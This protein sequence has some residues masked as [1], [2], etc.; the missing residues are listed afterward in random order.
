MFDQVQTSLPILGHRYRCHEELGSG[1]MGIVSRAYDRLTGQMVAVKLINVPPEYFEF[2][3]RATTSNL[4]V[5]LAREFQTLASLR[6]PNIISVLDYGFAGADQPF[7]VMELLENARELSAAGGDQSLEMQMRLIEQVL[8]ALKYLHRHRI[9]HCDLKPS[10]VLVSGQGVA[11]VLDFG[12]AL[13]Q[14]QE[15]ESGGTLSYMSPEVMAGG[16][17]TPLSDLYA[18]GVMAYELLVGRLPHYH[19]SL[20]KMAKAILETPTDLDPLPAEWREFVGRLLEKQPTARYA[21]A[22]EA[23]AALQRTMGQPETESISIRESYLQGAPFIGRETERETLTAALNRAKEGHGS[24]WLVSGES[25]VGKSRLL[26]ELRTQAQV[27]GFLVLRGQAVE[28]AGL[29]YQLWR[30]PL[31]R[32]ILPVE[33]GD[34]EAGVLKPVV[35]DIDRLLERPIT[36]AP[37]L[38]GEDGQQRLISTIVDLVKRQTE[39]IVLILEDLQWASESLTV[40]KQLNHFVADLPLL[41]LGNYRDDE[42]PNLPDE[43]PE[44]KVLSLKRLSQT[45]IATLSQSMLGEAGRQEPIVNLLQR[46]TEGNVFF[47]VEVVRALAEASGSLAQIGMMTLPAHIFAG[48]VR[49]VVQRRLG[50]MPEWAQPLL[51]LTALAGRQLD[52]AVLQTLLSEGDG[53]FTAERLEEWLSLGLDGAVLDF[54]DGQWRFAHD[55]LREAL[56]TDLIP[57]AVGNMHR[58]VAKAVEKVHSDDEAY[59]EALADHWG[60][61]GENERA[62]PY[63]LIAIKNLVEITTDYPRAEKLV[64][65]GLAYNS[66]TYQAALQMWYGEVA[67]KL[68]N[69]E[70]AISRFHE[71]LADVGD[72]WALRAQ[73]LNYLGTSMWRISRYPEART[74]ISQA[75]EIAQRLGDTRQSARCL[76]GLSRVSELTGDLE[77]SQEYS[78]QALVLFRDLD[79]WLGISRALN[80]LGIVVEKRGDYAKAETLYLESIEIATKMRFRSRVAYTLINL[81]IVAEYRE[82][83]ERACTYYDQAVA[84]FRDLGD[85]LGI[86]TCLLNK[87]NALF[88]LGQLD[89][90]RE[91]A[92]ESMHM[93]QQIGARYLIGYCHGLLGDIAQEQGD[94]LGAKTHY[95]S[96]QS[97][98]ADI[99]TSQEG[100]EYQSD[101]VIVLLRLGN[102]IASLPLLAEAIRG[103]FEINAPPT[104]MR[105]LRAVIY[106]AYVDGKFHE[107]AVW[108]G[109]FMNAQNKGVK[110]NL[111]RREL[112]EKLGGVLGAD[113]FA[114]LVE[115]GKAL[116]PKSVLNQVLAELT[117]ETKG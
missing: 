5:P 1:G 102:R 73:T 59:A 25:G 103:A 42:R 16:R 31:R 77:A 86:A 98:F 4:L 69:Y 8:Q 24:S 89:R 36:E 57:V 21:S 92:E 13:R 49:K 117:S 39:A 84:T 34:L 38:P 47:L 46:E 79:D 100:V 29:P 72:D 111:S 97:I 104:L 30:E 94:Y 81:G 91:L 101:L 114:E 19:A 62:L 44:M 63:L 109:L 65:R 41:I 15:A 95:Q 26:D 51:K 50:R 28:G 58:A 83:Y 7:L 112:S 88:G 10:N 23:L 2:M 78:E 9:V 107:S 45:E 110:A 11:R 3:S 76:W 33:L 54:Q 52:L 27:D 82:D 60:A 85:R 61:A 71:A 74:Y 64:E 43:L 93:V 80:S 66:P 35:P 37:E 90:A 87:G 70:L 67:N 99:G 106:L 12:L 14:G 17:A 20:E 113:R 68:S 75:L 108:L 115:Q 40:L 6:H 18:V 116:Q 96:A 32:L 22:G 48:G 53:G 105:V 56:L 55:K